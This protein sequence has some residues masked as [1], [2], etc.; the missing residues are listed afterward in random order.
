MIEKEKLVFVCGS[1]FF[2]YR[3]NVKL[4]VEVHFTVASQFYVH[5]NA[6]LYVVDAEQ[7]LELARG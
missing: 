6:E 7:Y 4:H 5:L 1:D 2:Q 3:F